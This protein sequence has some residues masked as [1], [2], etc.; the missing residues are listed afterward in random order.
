MEQIGR[1][2]ILPEAPAGPPAAHTPDPLHTDRPA[3]HPADLPPARIDLSQSGIP[4]DRFPFPIW[5]RLMR[6]ILSTRRREL[7]T[8]SPGNG[9]LELRTAIAQFLRQYQNLRVSP[10][11]IVIGAGTEYLYS[12]LIR[13]LGHDKIYA[14]ETPGYRKTERIYRS[15]AVEVRNIPMDRNGIDI[16]L[17]RESGADVVHI[18]PSHQF[19]TGITMPV[20]RRSELLSWHG[21]RR[22]DAKIYHRG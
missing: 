16:D 12:L 21:G 19:P 6:E 4:S 17:L 10:E 8:R 7:M 11:Q 5:S 18:S 13:L 9:I 3:D 20:A 15:S 22:E 14:M 2:L 1:S